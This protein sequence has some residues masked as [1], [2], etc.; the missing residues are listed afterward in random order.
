MLAAMATIRRSRSWK[1]T[2][3]KKVRKENKVK[4][5]LA[6]KDPPETKMATWLSRKMGR[7]RVAKQFNP[8]IWK[9]CLASSWAASMFWTTPRPLKTIEFSPMT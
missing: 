3:K 4:N 5:Q 2:T 7:T 9:S 1:S 6:L 8:S